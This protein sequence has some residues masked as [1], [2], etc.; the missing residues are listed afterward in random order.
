[1]KVFFRLLFISILLVLVFLA[2]SI[3]D[4]NIQELNADEYIAPEINN[5]NVTSEI[6]FVGENF[7]RPEKRTFNISQQKYEKSVVELIE[8]GPRNLTYGSIFDL[9]FDLISVETIKRTVYV[10]LNSNNNALNTLF[11]NKAELYLWS[12]VNSL[13]EKDDIYNVQFLFNGHTID[14][15]IDNYN[16]NDTLPRRD[17]L[18]FLKEIAPS[19]IV[20]S[21]LENIYRGR[22]DLAYTL[23]DERSQNNITYP[24]FIIKAQD[25]VN[26]TKDYETLLNFTQKHP[27]HWK[28]IYKYTDAEN[29]IHYLNWEVILEDNQYKIKL[30]NIDGDFRI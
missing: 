6:Y 17:E 12:I 4:V 13:T 9:G 16:L 7:L 22:Y 27:D 21:Y 3:E 20:D 2:I 11:N 29:T 8:K 28:I 24:E 26:D 25:F 10:N 30:K 18:I 14:Q 5:I 23:L 1:M 19:N 15:S